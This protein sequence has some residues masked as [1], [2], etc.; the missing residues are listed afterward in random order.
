MGNVA[1]TRLRIIT[2]I[3]KFIKDRGYAPTV[4]EIMK[5]CNIS[6]PS[7]VQY[8]LDRLEQAGYIERDPQVVRSIRLI[9]RGEVASVK[10]PILGT[11]A[12]GQPIPVPSS[13][14]WDATSEETLQLTEDVTQGREGIFALRVKGTSMIDALI[15]D[16]DIV[17]MQQANS[18]EDGEMVAVWLKDKQEVTLKKFYVEQE[19]VCLR[20][21]NHLMAPIYQRPDNVEIQGKVVGVI[22]KL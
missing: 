7:V 8:H 11:I 10:V 18:A 14:T 13:D 4:R 1:G 5:G 15:G 20:S 6:V 19:R 12:A 22:R 16:G 9:E 21:A 17:L 3:G 2:F